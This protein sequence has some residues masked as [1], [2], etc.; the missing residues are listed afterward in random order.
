MECHTRF[1]SGEQTASRSLDQDA[2]GLKSW[3]MRLV[4]PC[5]LQKLGDVLGDAPG[6]FTARSIV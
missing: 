4:R 5:D 3:S 6:A 2:L 1:C